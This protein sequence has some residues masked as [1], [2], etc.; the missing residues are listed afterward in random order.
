MASVRYVQ[1]SHAFLGVPI[2]T[3]Q[4]SETSRLERPHLYKT[5]CL[6]LDFIGTRPRLVTE[7]ATA[8][9][10]RSSFLGTCRPYMALLAAV[11][12]LANARRVFRTRCRY[13]AIFTAVIAKL[14]ICTLRDEVS[15]STATVALQLD[16][17]GGGGHPN[18]R[19]VQVLWLYKKPCRMN[20]M[21]KGADNA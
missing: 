7:R 17:F 16:S 4:L 19:S 5:H 12:T 18:R 15:K 10:P 6:R 11:I 1:P 8:S 13:V 2:Q 9:T 21:L 3:R 14:L 20:G